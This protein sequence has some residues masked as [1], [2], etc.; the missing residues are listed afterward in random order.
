M[1]NKNYTIRALTTEEE[2]IGFIRIGIAAFS[3]N[4]K[5]MDGEIQSWLTDFQNSPDLP[6]ENIRGAI[7]NETGAVLGGYVMHDRQLCIQSARLR[8]ACIGAVAVDA[9]QRKQGVGSALMWDAVSFAETH[10]YPLLYLTGVANYYHRFGYVTMIDYPDIK[11]KR[12]DIH[13]LGAIGDEIELRPATKADA[14]V[15]LALYQRHFETYPSVFDR[16]LEMQRYMLVEDDKPEESEYILA[17]SNGFPIGY[18]ARSSSPS[19]FWHK[20]TAAEGW[21]ALAALLREYEREVS[22][23]E[24]KPENVEKKP[25]STITWHIPPHSPMFYHMQANIPF[26]SHYQHH[27]SAD[28]MARM[29][30]LDLFLDAMLPLWTGR[31]LAANPVWMGGLCVAIDDRKFLWRFEEEGFEIESIASELDREPAITLTRQD[32]VQLSFGFRPISWFLSQRENRIENP[33]MHQTVA[34]LFPAQTAWVAGTDF[35]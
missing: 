3:N 14:S 34:T 31:W 21:P 24:A 5:D 26:D 30:D 18:M 23:K 9:Q 16:S 11:V 17:L 27:F 28:W 33:Y 19:D 32:L 4:V 22:E 29:G 13:A 2:Q 7:D 8:T 10:G 1:Q 15:L 12:S 25:Q 6:T 35:F 20:E